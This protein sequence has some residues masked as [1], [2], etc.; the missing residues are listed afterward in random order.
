MEQFRFFVGQLATLAY[1]V[2]LC[3]LAI[4]ATGTER[5]KLSLPIDC[6]IRKN[7]W[8]VNLVD[9]DPG[10]GRRDYLCGK[11]TYDTHKGTDFAVRDLPAMKKGVSVLAAA[12][13]I[14]KAVRDGMADKFPDEALRRSKNIHCGNGL[15]IS[16]AHG[17]E[18]QYC[19]LRKG[20]V[21]VRTGIKVKRGQKLGLVGHSG[22]AEF[23]H[24]HLS[25]RQLGEAVD[26]F[27]GIRLSEANNIECGALTSSLWN[28][29]AKHALAIS[30]T[31]FF[32]AG[33]AY[34]E[35]TRQNINKGIY[36]LRTFPRSSNV[37][38]F[39]VQ[40]WWVRK[41]DI[42]KLKIIDPSG[43]ELLNNS[44]EMKKH[45]SQYMRYAGKR[46]DRARWDPGE[47]TGT[48]ELIRNVAG[49]TKLFSIRRKILMQD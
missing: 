3:L 5:P 46:K 13:G 6:S 30:M 23:P 17:W 36:Q 15:V 1:A 47:Y 27:L 21:A 4:P 16:H 10:P 45:Q 49:K 11:H 48:G 7:C 8:L 43:R 38:I 26:P 37:L 41:S 2:F 34:E 33:F 40:A 9:L 12:P 39:W 22:M 44:S 19:H 35:P 29:K 42:L 28:K 20:S 31:S 24:L 25:V 32:N 14:V 18:T